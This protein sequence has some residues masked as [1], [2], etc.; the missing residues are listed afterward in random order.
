[1]VFKAFRFQRAELTSEEQAGALMHLYYGGLN[2]IPPQ[3]PPKGEVAGGPEELNLLGAP[4]L[5]R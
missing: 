5:E 4:L 2:Q 3:G 1:M